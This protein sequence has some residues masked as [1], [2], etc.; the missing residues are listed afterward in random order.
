MLKI[1]KWECKKQ[2]QL[3]KT[4]LGGLLAVFLLMVLFPASLGKSSFIGIQLMLMLCSM[5][6]GFGMLGFSLYPIYNMVSDFTKKHYIMERMTQRS[7][8]MIFT[9]KLIMNCA[10]FFIAALIGYAGS[11]LMSKF[12][13]ETRSFFSVDMSQPYLKLMF[14]FVILY[15]STVVFCYLL[16]S[17]LPIIKRN[18]MAGT[19]LGVIILGIASTFVA[20]KGI[21]YIVVI[22]LISCLFLAVSGKLA[23][24]YYEQQ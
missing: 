8:F 24:N 19:I 1:L 7:Y 13:T 15:P 22:I 10:S 12:T 23:D 3:I 5:S 11:N 16:S 9:V 4:V 21:T 20:L 6:L 2:F 17:T 14:E 18:R